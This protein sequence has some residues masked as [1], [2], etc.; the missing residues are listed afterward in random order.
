MPF[1]HIYSC[2][3]WSPYNWHWLYIC[4]ITEYHAYTSLQHQWQTLLY[5]VD[6]GLCGQNVLQS[7]VWLIDS[8]IYVFVIKIDS[9]QVYIYI[10]MCINI[11]QNTTIR[12]C[13]QEW[14][15]CLWLFHFMLD[16]WGRQSLVAIKYNFSVPAS[17]THQYWCIKLVHVIL[18]DYNL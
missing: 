17:L 8:A 3:R 4:W 13:Q 10:Y 16:D 15:S 1:T 6:K 11:T 18:S 12:K 5:A 9:L 2:P 14:N 7:V